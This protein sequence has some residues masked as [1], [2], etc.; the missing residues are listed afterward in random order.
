M[1]LLNCRSLPKHQ[2]EI[3]TLLQESVIEIL[4]LTET[5]INLNSEPDIVQ[6]LPPG[7]LIK[8]QDRPSG[9]GGG[10]AII[11]RDYLVCHFK[12]SPIQDCENVLFSIHLPPSTTLSEILVYRPPGQQR[13]FCNS[14]VET[15]SWLS[16]LSPNFTV[17]GDLNLHFDD[18]TNNIAEDL[19]KDLASLNLHLKGNQPTHSKGHLLDPIFTNLT[20]LV[21]SYGSTVSQL[22]DKQ[23]FPSFLRTIPCDEYQSRVLANLIG[24]LGWTWVGVLA[25][26]TDYGQLGSQ[27]LID[28]LAKYSVCAAFHERLP[29]EYSQSRINH[30][31]QVIKES[32]AKVIVAF[33]SYDFMFPLVKEARRLNLTGRVW[34]GSDAWVPVD[35][36]FINGSIVI[37][38]RK[39]VLPGFRD[40]VLRLLPSL[41]AANNIL[42]DFKKIL[43]MRITLLHYVRKVR[44]RSTAGE[45]VF[46]DAGGNPPP[47]YEIL[48]WKITA[49]G[50]EEKIVVGIYQPGNTSESVLTLNNSLIQ[51]GGYDQIPQSSCNEMCTV[52]FRKSTRE[53]QGVCCFDCIPCSE[54]EISNHT[55]DCMYCPDDQWSNEKRDRCVLKY[56]E[57]LSI[58]EPLGFILIS[59]ATASTMVVI[60][61][62]A[63][64]FK[65]R[66]TP[67]VK[68]NN[69]GL[70]Y[71]L[72]ISLSLCLLSTLLFLGRP[73]DITCMLRQV[74]FSILFVMCISCLLAK[75]VLVLMAFQATHPN[76]PL[77]SGLGPKIPT[78]IVFVC[79]LIQAL[80]CTVWLAFFHPYAE[81]N[82]KSQTWKVILE[83]NEG[84]PTAF[85]CVL[86]YMALLA[87][88]SFLIAFKA[89]KLPDSFNEAQLIT[90]SMVTFLTVWTLF[91][92]SYQ[93]TKGKYMVAVGV[94]TIIS[95][96]MGIVVCI[97]LP[98][99]YI[100]VIR[101]DLN[102]RNYLR[103][104]LQSLTSVN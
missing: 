98:K 17:L 79:T 90:F 24:L 66:E 99:C 45:D 50:V 39:S 8:H 68:A 31:I 47:A 100:I 85:W 36:N 57:F 10:I 62:F 95:S 53:G 23:H 56:V 72:L 87:I 40:S 42:F 77:R 25:E 2:I 71:L 43:L 13:S 48:N 12:D 9:T 28:E 78:M 94:F 1:A 104:K 22:S 6:T 3:N 4:F 83:C 60:T 84:S 96:S 73:T 101:P 5:W 35:F 93:N 30:I 65:H 15:T 75:T 18:L 19:K 41:I 52:G 38:I 70:S 51:L 37:G 55:S 86:G 11:Y 88:T 97:F 34:I 27:L 102:S 103:G 49:E 59:V 58:Q 82:M 20:N 89:R 7:Y 44:F 46:F 29:L 61:I 81:K 33:A 69:L 14:L 67:I 63:V 21:I 92:P 80:I 74:T 26:D 76:T 32:R 16:C 91:L 64:F 54:G